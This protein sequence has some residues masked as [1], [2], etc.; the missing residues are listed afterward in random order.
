MSVLPSGRAPEDPTES[1]AACFV[2]FFGPARLL[3][4]VRE[5]SLP[6]GPEATVGAVVLALAERYPVLAGLVLDLER[7]MPA[8]GYIFNRNG[9]D[10][11]AEPDSVVRP[12]DRLLLLASAAGG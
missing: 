12:G 7:R 5:V 9:R 8:N 11:L 10:F 1:Q 2:E 6:I 4:P 3:V